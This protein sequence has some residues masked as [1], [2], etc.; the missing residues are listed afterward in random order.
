VEDFLTTKGWKP[1]LECIVPAPPSIDRGTQPVVLLA[2]GLAKRMGVPVF[3]DAVRKA[4][5]TPS[6][7]NIDDWFERQRI[8]SKAVQPG[9]DNVAE[10]SILLLDDLIQSGSTLR[11][12]AEVLLDDCKAKGIY[13][14]VLTRTR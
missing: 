14:L 1:T 8:L 5:K 11:R 4:E 7:K 13:A 6:M 10:K 2:H 3:I 9:K 12:A